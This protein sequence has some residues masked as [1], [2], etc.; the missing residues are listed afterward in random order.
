MKENQERLQKP[1]AIEKHQW[2]AKRS[3]NV[4][5]GWKITFVWSKRGN[6][7]LKQISK[8]TLQNEGDEKIDGEEKAEHGNLPLAWERPRILI[9]RTK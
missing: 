3:T 7:I 4:H 1:N 5:W 6:R 9:L 8:A 2:G